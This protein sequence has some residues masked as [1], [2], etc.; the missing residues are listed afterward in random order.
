MMASPFPFRVI[1][2]FRGPTPARH[3]FLSFSAIVRVIPWQYQRAIPLRA[4]ASP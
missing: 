2:V 3:V 1:R 4:S